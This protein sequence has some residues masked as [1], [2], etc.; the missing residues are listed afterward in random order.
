MSLKY[1][2]EQLVN[3]LFQLCVD[4]DVSVTHLSHI[5]RSF[6]RIFRLQELIGE[7]IQAEILSISSSIYGESGFHIVRNDDNVLR[8][9]IS[10]V[11]KEANDPHLFLSGDP[12]SQQMDSLQQ[13]L[14]SVG[15]MGTSNSNEPVQDDIKSKVNLLIDTY[16]NYSTVSL[17]PR[18]IKLT[19][20]FLLYEY[21][22]HQQIAVMVDNG[23]TNEVLRPLNLH[24]NDD[25]FHY[26]YTNFLTSIIAQ[27]D[28]SEGQLF[29]LSTALVQTFLDMKHVI[30]IIDLKMLEYFNEQAVLLVNDLAPASDTVSTFFAT[31]PIFPTFT[32]SKNNEKVQELTEHF[33][34]VET[35]G[36]LKDV[37]SVYFT[38]E[39]L[40]AKYLNLRFFHDIFREYAEII[41]N[42]AGPQDIYRDKIFQ[43][44]EKYCRLRQIDNLKI[45][46]IELFEQPTEDFAL[47]IF[48][49]KSRRKLLH[50]TL[51]HWFTVH[52]NKQIDDEL[53]VIWRNY[54]QKAYLKKWSNAFRERRNQSKK[55]IEVHHSLTRFLY[56]RVWS[57][58]YAVHQALNASSHLLFKRKYFQKW[59]LKKANVSSMDSLIPKLNLHTTGPIFDIWL[60]NSSLMTSQLSN[61]KNKRLL[62]ECL[63][64]WTGKSIK[65]RSLQLLSDKLQSRTLI[66]KFFYPWVTQII[67]VNS[68]KLNEKGKLFVYSRFFS[69]W[70]RITHLHSLAEKIGLMQE[71]N[72]R[73]YTFNKWAEACN[74]I[75]KANGFHRGKVVARAFSQWKLSMVAKKFEFESGRK[76]VGRTFKVIHLEAKGR[77]IIHKQDRLTMK[78]IFSRWKA[79]LIINQERADFSRFHY[80]AVTTRKLLFHWILKRDRVVTNREA[81]IRFH[82]KVHFRETQTLERQIFQF[83]IALSKHI[84]SKSKM[85]DGMHDSLVN[86]K[87]YKCYLNIWINKSNEKAELLTKAITLREKKLK[88]LGLDIWI[89]SLSEIDRM[90]LM[91]RE[92]ID[93]NFTRV[94]QELLRDWRMKGLKW[95]G[96]FQKAIQ[97]EKRWNH[98]RLATLWLVWQDSYKV[99]KAKKSRRSSPEKLSNNVNQEDAEMSTSL[100]GTMSPLANRRKH[101]DT[102]AR[103]IQRLDVFDVPQLAPGSPT[104]PTRRGHQPS[105]TTPGR[106]R[107]ISP[108]PRISPTRTPSLNGSPEDLVP[109]TERIRRTRVQTLKK[110]YAAARITEPLVSDNSRSMAIEP[111]L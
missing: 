61:A 5:V 31:N 4:R 57:N 33:G 69:R 85:L 18:L 62:R 64:S 16:A 44:V 28:L 14:K 110:R 26:L 100:E 74:D 104:T 80:E 40:T 81:A 6:Q 58:R 8:P 88:T 34:L 103:G 84:I 51:T 70:K 17:T 86:Q 87:L 45:L 66:S 50:K 1:D 68:Q 93:E 9:S 21:K 67:H 10:N 49:V 89:N 63:A 60:L 72:L 47:A 19:H 91:C 99:L 11:I 53:M 71:L 52:E 73:K 36:L 32:D 25:D 23:E 46:C 102:L 109:A 95:N 13:E 55:A 48:N 106:V 24:V 56:F 108:T 29:E 77:S 38:D 65:V 2:I 42:E 12:F 39:F 96:E 35:F 92:K 54:T 30:G 27:S 101:L 78:G 43:K 15:S 79:Q 82:R 111:F 94:S 97:F 20:R 22:Y 37:V 76:L 3:L 98:N 90:E 107:R 83:W 75:R 7:H 105:F 41:V 59:V